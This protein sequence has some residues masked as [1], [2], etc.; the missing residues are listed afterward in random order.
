MWRFLCMHAT[1]GECKRSTAIEQQALMGIVMV[2]LTTRFM[3]Q[4]AQD[5]GCTT[6]DSTQQHK[7][8]AKQAERQRSA[9]GVSLRAGLCR[10][11]AQS[12]VFTRY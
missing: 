7:H 3:H 9:I 5:L 11:E 6:P 2:V 10:K 8:H 4:R 12:A 1:D